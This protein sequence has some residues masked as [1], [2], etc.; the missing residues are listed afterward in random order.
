MMGLAISTFLV[1]LTLLLILSNLGWWDF[2][3]CGSQGRGGVRLAALS[4]ALLVCILWLKLRSDSYLW[5]REENIER[6]ELSTPATPRLQI[7]KE[8]PDLFCKLCSAEALPPPLPYLP[9]S[10][11]GPSRSE[12]RFLPTG[13]S[14]LGWVSEPKGDPDQCGGY[15][16]VWKCFIRF[17][18]PSNGHPIEVAVKVLRKVDLHQFGDAE[19]HQRILA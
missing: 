2:E 6:G 3:S 14:F 11:S 10:S 18:E 17:C 12:F 1:T 9:P 16:D 8:E 5:S 4:V 13:P 7:A 15:S 19:S